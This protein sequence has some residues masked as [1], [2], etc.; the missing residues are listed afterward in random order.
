MRAPERAAEA[1]VG[2]FLHA[3]LDGEIADRDDL[4][5]RGKE[6]GIDA[7]PRRQRARRARARP[8]DR[9]RTTGARACSRSPS[10]P[11]AGDRAGRDR[12]CRARGR[13]RR[14]VILAAD[15]DGEAR[16]PRRG[17]ACC[18]SWTANLQRL[19]VRGRPQPRRAR[20][21]RPA[22]RRQRGAA[23]RERRRGRPG[24]GAAVVR[25]HR[26]PTSCCCRHMSDDPAEL[27]RFY[28]E[29]VSK[30]V[31]Y[32]EQYETRPRRHAGDVPR[33]DGTWPRPP[34]GSS[35]TATRS[36]TASSA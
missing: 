24:R 4:V 25:R 33:Y 21:G 36:A 5:A 3:V 11:R 19:R 35:P 8:R 18:A 13:R 30:L 31:A 6:L 15:A 32:D 10:V 26:A 34:R 16:P 14:V 7:R 9:P 1:A 2:E 12:R 20:P 23:G 27:K 29:T 17:D 28:D 22:P